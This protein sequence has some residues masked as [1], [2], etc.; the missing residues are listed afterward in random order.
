MKT[1]LRIILA[2]V[3]AALAALAALLLFRRPP[4]PRFEMVARLA[5][6]ARSEGVWDNSG[7]GP[8]KRSPRSSPA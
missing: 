7:T 6:M 1:T 5:S 3:A 2:A 4:E 8:R